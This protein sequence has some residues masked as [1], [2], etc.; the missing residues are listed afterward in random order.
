[1]DVAQIRHELQFCGSF[2]LAHFLQQLHEM[3]GTQFAWVHL[4]EKN[5]ESVEF[6]Y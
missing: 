3:I 4:A 1:V 2:E 5:E 6:L